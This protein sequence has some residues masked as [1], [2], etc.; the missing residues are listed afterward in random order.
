MA[1]T[2]RAFVGGCKS[3]LLTAKQANVRI[4][5]RVFPGLGEMDGNW[6]A[7]LAASDGRQSFNQV[8]G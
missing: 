1:M 7:L 8:P 6:A 4:E 5:H 2:R 3:A